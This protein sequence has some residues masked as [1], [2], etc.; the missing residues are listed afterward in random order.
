MSVLRHMVFSNTRYGKVNS[1]GSTA[2]LYKSHLLNFGGKEMTCS[3]IG[4]VRLSSSS[5]DLVNS[6][7]DI[8]VQSFIGIE[9]DSETN[10]RS[11][12]SNKEIGGMELHE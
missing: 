1:V 3:S 12:V 5:E 8:F 6:I 11:N 7:L 9:L 10:K 2:A 4:S